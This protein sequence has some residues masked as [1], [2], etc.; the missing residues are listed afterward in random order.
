VANHRVVD[1][2]LALSLERNGVQGHVR[3]VTCQRDV[4]QLTCHTVDRWL[5][6]AYQ[7]ALDPARREGPYLPSY[8]GQ[9]TPPVAAPPTTGQ[10]TPAVAAPSTTE[11]A[12]V[13]GR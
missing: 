6:G 12:S 1:F 8:T 5:D 11:Q 3:L 4:R 10:A 7:Q 9:G 2:L 13:A